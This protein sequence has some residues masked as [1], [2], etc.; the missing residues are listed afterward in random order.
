LLTGYLGPAFDTVLWPFLGFFFMPYTTCAY[1][2]GINEAGGFQGWSLIVLIIGVML[3]FTG[4]G[5]TA[6]G[7]RS[8]Y[9]HIEYRK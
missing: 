7:G 9:M 2:I 4:H 5:G 3:D 1:A 8:R 6:A